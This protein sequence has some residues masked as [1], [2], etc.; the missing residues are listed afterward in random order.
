MVVKSGA[1]SRAIVKSPNIVP[2][3]ILGIVSSCAMVT[4]SLR[5]VVFQQTSTRFFT[6]RMPFLSPNRTSNSDRVAM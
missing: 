4:L 5:R 6:G 3:H 2:F 1:I